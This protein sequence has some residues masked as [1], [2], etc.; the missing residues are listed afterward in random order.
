M[1]NVTSISEATLTETALTHF[2]Y[3]LV[4]KRNT[5]DDLKQEK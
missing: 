5:E 4:F 2:Y 3:N 1:I